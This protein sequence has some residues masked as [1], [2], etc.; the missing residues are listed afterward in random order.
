MLGHFNLF[1]INFSVHLHKRKTL[2]EASPGLLVSGF[3]VNCCILKFLQVNPIL[4]LISVRL[5][6]E[7][8]KS[9]VIHYFY[10]DMIEVQK[11]QFQIKRKLHRVIKLCKNPNLG[12]TPDCGIP[13]VT[14]FKGNPN[15]SCGLN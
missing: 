7:I 1:Q 2:I 13:K 6:I 14:I 9:N 5:H 10:I 3:S 15:L 11:Q 8:S 4:F 12:R